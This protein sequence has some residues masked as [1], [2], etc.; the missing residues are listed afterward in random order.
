MKNDNNPELLVRKVIFKDFRESAIQIGI[1]EL[2]KALEHWPGVWWNAYSEKYGFKI[3]EFPYEARN[4]FFIDTK[5]RIATHRFDSSGI[6]RRDQLF[7]EPDY[8]KIVLPQYRKTWFDIDDAVRCYSIL[9]TKITT[10]EETISVNS[11]GLYNSWGRV[12]NNDKFKRPR[13]IKAT[14]NL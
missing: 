2:Q 4:G 6:A 8:S 9:I 13:L 5:Q 14:W 12:S 3:K 11:F 10:L 1:S 7:T